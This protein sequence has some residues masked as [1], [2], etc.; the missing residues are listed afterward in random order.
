MSVRVLPAFVAVII[1]VV[2]ALV[3]FV[4]FV[5]RA[6]RRHGHLG[7]GRTFLHFAALLYALGLAAYV[8]IPLPPTG[9]GFCAALAHLT[10]QWEP[11]RWLAGLPRPGSAADVTSLLS[12]STVQQF[13]FNVLLFVPLGML[14]RHL[15]RAGVPLTVLLGFATSLF[16][17]LTQLTGIWFLYPCPYRLFDVDDLLANTLGAAFGSA[18]A[19]VLRLVS[20]PA[21]SDAGEPRPVGVG[22]RLLGMVCDAL[23]LWWC[24]SAVLRASEVLLRETPWEGTIAART[25]AL[26]FTPA[27]ALLLC[28]VFGRGTTLGQHAVLLRAT[29]RDGR[30]PSAQEAVVRWLGGLGGLAVV[31]GFLPLLDVPRA[32]AF[33]A[34]AWCTIHAFGVTRTHDRRGITGVLAGLTVKDARED[35]ASLRPP[36]TRTTP[37]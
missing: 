3:L 17:E 28:T 22:R 1:A 2:L 11:L 13:G 5:A 24:G 32:G 23:L 19:P 29:R 26:W 34:L 25:L 9:P 35:D 21:G 8:L 16:V 15:A 18:L 14:A 30:A 31:Q 27:F 10:P 20:G 6:H 7:P 12:Y 4:P 33:V 36:V 37:Q